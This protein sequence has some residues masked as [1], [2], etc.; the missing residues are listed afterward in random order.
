M[1][2]LCSNFKPK[3]R[4]FHIMGPDYGMLCLNISLYDLGVINECSDDLSVGMFSLALEI[5]H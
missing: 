5:I 2:E 1:S 3:G 4:L